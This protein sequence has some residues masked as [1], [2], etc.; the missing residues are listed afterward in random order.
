M[1]ERQRS[2]GDGHQSVPLG[3]VERVRCDAHLACGAQHG[4]EIVGVVGRGDEQQGLR[5]GGMATDPVAEELLD[6][7]ADGQQVGERGR[8]VQLGRR[9]CLGELGQGQR[10][11]EGSGAAPG[12][13]RL[14]RRACG[15]VR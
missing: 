13:V 8:P 2:S 11:A 5:V 15:R 1:P 14:R 7:G 4:F 9:Q 10:V 12:R 6:V 3:R